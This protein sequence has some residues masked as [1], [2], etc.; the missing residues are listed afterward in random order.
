MDEG[1]SLQAL[2]DYTGSRLQGNAE[3]RLH[4]VVSIEKAQ[5]GEL[6]YVRSAKYRHFLETSHASALILPPDL[7]ETYRGD[8]LVNQNP[9]LAYAKAVTL[10]HSS[11]PPNA[12]I[13]PSAVIAEDAELAGLCSI[14]AK[15]VIESGTRIASGVIIEAGC[16]I[17]RDCRIGENSRLYPNV[18]LYPGTEIGKRCIIH[19]GAVLGADGFGFAP[20]GKAWFKIPQ[21]G[22]VVVGNDVEIGANTC[23][24]RAAMGSTIIGD[25]VKLDNLLQIAH[26][27]QIGEHTAMAA[28]TAVAGSVRIG[29]Y[30]Q[31]GGMSAI[32]GHLDIT[33]NVVVTGTSLVSHSLTKPGV[34]SSGTTVVDNAVWRKNAVRFNQLD[35]LARRLQ[36]LE[37][38]LAV[39]QDKGSN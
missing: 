36:E 23:I 26:N 11:P 8:C 6:S 12:G 3:L 25:G 17:G 27:V 16:V 21:V 28:C 37:R 35:K 22:N 7:A 13:H 31:I 19:A 18:T 5:A 9:Y 24:D 34:Y 20:D 4:A 1:H 33:D 2:A 30:C 38:Q 32:A 29:R 14:G 10:L 15:V 39:L